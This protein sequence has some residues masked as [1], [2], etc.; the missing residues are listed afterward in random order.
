MKIRALVAGFS[1]AVLLGA[2]SASP[3]LPAT[4]SEATVTV[5]PTPSADSEGTGGGMGSGN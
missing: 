5:A 1:L 3:T 4:E 2:C